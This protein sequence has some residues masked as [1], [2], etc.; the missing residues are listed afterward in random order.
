MKYI[1]IILCWEKREK[2]FTSFSP[3]IKFFALVLSNRDLS[4]NKKKLKAGRRGLVEGA[5]SLV[6]QGVRGLNPVDSSCIN[7]F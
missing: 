6:D 4:G 1:E 7:F 3:L 5:R 2:R